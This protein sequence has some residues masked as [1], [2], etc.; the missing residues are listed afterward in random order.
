MSLLDQQIS[1]KDRFNDIM[2]FF[3]LFIVVF[4]SIIC[5]GYLK[6]LIKNKIDQSIYKRQEKKLLS[7]IN[8]KKSSHAY[9]RFT[10]TEELFLKVDLVL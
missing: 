10:P 4:G 6:T 8:Y 2:I 1:I 7:N 3:I 9:E 5:F